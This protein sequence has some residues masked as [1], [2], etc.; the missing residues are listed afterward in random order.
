MIQWDKAPREESSF[1]LHKY[2]VQLKYVGVCELLLST[3]T[4]ATE[5]DRDHKW[6]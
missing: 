6:H 4:C 2:Q 3:E 5:R 1:T